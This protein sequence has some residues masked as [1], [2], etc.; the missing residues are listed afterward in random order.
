MLNTVLQE[1]SIMDECSI[2]NNCSEIKGLEQR[3]F[4]LSQFINESKLLLSQQLNFTE[5]NINYNT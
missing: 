4:K 1:I 3:L 2:Q 5:V